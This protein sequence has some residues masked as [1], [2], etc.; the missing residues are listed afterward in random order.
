MGLLSRWFERSARREAGGNEIDRAMSLLDAGE[1]GKAAACLKRVLTTDP[2]NDRA[3]YLL[4][5]TNVTCKDYGRA[6]VCFE[7]VLALRPRDTDVQLKVDGLRRVVEGNIGAQA[8]Y[9]VE[10]T[11]VSALFKVSV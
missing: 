4:A 6:L 3:W 7:Q 10:K 1:Y 5:T 11:L 9:Q 2:R 8:A